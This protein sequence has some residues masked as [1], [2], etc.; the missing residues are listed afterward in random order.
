ME[1]EP[2]RRFQTTFDLSNE[3]ADRYHL[4]SEQY[5]RE[6]TDV[7]AIQDEIAMNIV[8]ALAVELRMYTVPVMVDKAGT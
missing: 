2:A 6:L 7:F 8:R 4:W 3:L 1:K 5:D